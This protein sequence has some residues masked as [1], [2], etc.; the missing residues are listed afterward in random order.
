[1]S[2]YCHLP[3]SSMASPF[4]VGVYWPCPPCNRGATG[5]GHM[6][7]LAATRPVGWVKGISPATAGVNSSNI[8]IWLICIFPD[9]G[10]PLPALISFRHK[11]GVSSASPSAATTHDVWVRTLKPQTRGILLLPA[12]SVQFL[13]FKEKKCHRR[14]GETDPSRQSG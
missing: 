10:K 5:G 9:W 13:V 6:W 1:M 12:F 14:G 2:K 11:R 7:P 8:P 3:E 4:R